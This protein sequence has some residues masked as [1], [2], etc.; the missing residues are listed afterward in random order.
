LKNRY[1]PII[2]VCGALA[3]LII[4]GQFMP[5]P[6]DALPV[7]IAMQ[8]QGG[9]VVFT[10]SR[11]VEY[12]EK[13][14]GDCVTCHHEGKVMST[15]IPVSCGSCHAAEFD[16]GFSSAHQ[17]ELPRDTC[18]YCHHAELGTLVYSHDDHASDYNDDCTDCHHGPDI[19]SEPGACNQCH[20]DTAEDDVPSLRDAVHA[21]CMDCHEDM[22]EAEL[23]GCKDC[24]ELLPGK[25]EG[26]QPSCNSCHF[27]TEDIP[28][29]TRMESY[30]DQCMGCH[31]QAKAGPYGDQSCKQCHTR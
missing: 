16:A 11:H 31:E 7:R 22:Y 3:L 18:T 10:H 24:H 15:L 28:L 25:I 20:G 30:H 27:E 23:D 12:V 29:R 26:A 21:K 19:E 6:S 2:G 1:A 9:N 14:D 8:N 4:G 17:T 13:R 5:A